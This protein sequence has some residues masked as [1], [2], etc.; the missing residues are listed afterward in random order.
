MLT[1]A[2]RFDCGIQGQQ[3]G[4]ERDAIDD[5]GDLDDFFGEAADCLHRL[6]DVGHDFAAFAGDL[7]GLLGKRVC[8]LGMGA[9][10]S[11]CGGQLFH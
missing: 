8:F 6:D 2:G 10:L 7:Q 9:V 11:D 1:C 5:G 4:L 3:I